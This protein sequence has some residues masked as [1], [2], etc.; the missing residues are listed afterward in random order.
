M[1]YYR[2]G[3]DED[4]DDFDEY[5][6]NPYSGGYDMALTYGR[7]L[8]PSEETCYSLTESTSGEDF[9][10]DRPQYSDYS[11]PAAYADNALET[12]YSS[13]AKYKPRPGSGPQFGAPHP[14]DLHRPGY[15]GSLYGSGRTD[16]DDSGYGRRPSYGDSE[17][18]APPP[19]PP[20]RQSYVEPEE[21]DA[22]PPPRPSYGRPSFGGSEYDPPPRRHNYGESEDY[23]APPP[24]RP[25]YG[26]ES[27]YGGGDY[28]PPR[29]Q[30]YGKSEEYDAPPPPR[31]ETYGRP[32]YGESEEHDA[33]PPL[34]PSY[35]GESEFGGGDYPPPGRQSYGREEGEE[36]QRPR[37]ERSEEQEYRKPSYGGE[38]EGSYGRRKKYGSYAF[39]RCACAAAELEVEIH[40]VLVLRTHG[41]MPS[42][43]A[44]LKYAVILTLPKGSLKPHEAWNSEAWTVGPETQY[45]LGT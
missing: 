39:H 29:R 43:E 1:S 24:P 14:P 13:Y 31:R 37:Y 22:P 20:R 9:D 8:P 21:Y 33:P 16:Q 38:E 2:K 12:E 6:P 15:G 19:H 23:D 28:P 18:D 40:M 10:Y 45:R 36:Y 41:F 44:N 27:E 34:R 4:V 26:G 25:S 3:E 35:G 17:Y 42:N 5:D 11:E 30:I 7:P 32:S